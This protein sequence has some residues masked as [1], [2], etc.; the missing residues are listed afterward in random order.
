[1][2]TFNAHLDSSQAPVL[3]F[4]D[5]KKKKKKKKKI[6][7]YFLDGS[8]LITFENAISSTK[9]KKKKKKTNERNLYMSDESFVF[10]LPRI[11]VIAPSRD[12]VNFLVHKVS[13]PMDDN[14]LFARNTRSKG[15]DLMRNSTIRDID[16]IPNN[17][18]RLRKGHCKHWRRKG[19]ASR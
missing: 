1:M 8:L 14:L 16:L 10:V 19:F 4:L 13:K 3:F 12:I 15:A 2:S 5:D 11:Q 18:F 6:N 17:F 9:K 7:Y